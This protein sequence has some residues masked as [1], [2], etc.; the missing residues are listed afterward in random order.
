M[1][2]AFDEE[3]QRLAGV[4]MPDAFIFGI[5]KVNSLRRLS[6]PQAI[7]D[8][9]LELVARRRRGLLSGLTRL[10]ETSRKV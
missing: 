1:R 10:A 9:Y 2:A 5:P 3:S 7:D 4:T 6:L 8:C